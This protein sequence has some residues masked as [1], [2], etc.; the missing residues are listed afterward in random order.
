MCLLP[1]STLHLVKECPLIAGVQWHYA[2]FLM[3]LAVFLPLDCCIGG[4]C[5]LCVGCWVAHPDCCNADWEGFQQ[6]YLNMYFFIKGAVAIIVWTHFMT[7]TGLLWNI[8]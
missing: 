7:A 5:W 6:V 1:I 8:K 2:T 4:G 3:P